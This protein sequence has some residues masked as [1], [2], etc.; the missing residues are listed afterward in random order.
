MELF[1]AAFVIITIFSLSDGSEVC[2]KSGRCY[3][4][5][6]VFRHL[7][8]PLCP[9]DMDIKTFL[10]TRLNRN[11]PVQVFINPES[12]NVLMNDDLH[13][14]DP[15]NP[16]IFTT[17][18]W[19]GHGELD[20]LF[21]QKDFILDRLD[22]NVLIIDWE[23][24]ANHY[25][26]PKAAACT[27]TAGIS[28][29]LVM[30]HMV[31]KMNVRYEQIWCVGFSLGAHHCGHAGMNTKEKIGRITG[32]DPAGPLFTK[33]DKLVRLNP[34]AAV[35]VD[36]IHTDGTAIFL[37]L[38]LM[39]R[40][41]HADF[42]PNG[43][44]KQPGCYTRQ[45]LKYDP[46]TFG[47]VMEYESATYEDFGCMHYRAVRYF[48]ESFQNKT[49]HVTKYKCEDQYNLPGSCSECNYGCPI[50]GVE[51]INERPHGIFYLKTE[52]SAPFCRYGN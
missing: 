5:D 2:C 38:G 51:A 8:L 30:D 33:R 34:D 10:Y 16:T 31:E 19:L 1:S 12:D 3:H 42:Y 15:L 7:P 44:Q 18:G 28:T 27:R 6:G 40:V 35:Y 52:S 43:G 37:A 39:D 13:V 32:L 48:E 24:G 11:N 50:M 49:C 47:E 17:H 36:V 20:W 25:Y 45:N 46:E 9:E 14:F 29:A 22:A 21:E 26:Y 4:N 23:D 41:G